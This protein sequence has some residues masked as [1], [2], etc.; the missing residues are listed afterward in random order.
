MTEVYNK[1]VGLTKDVGWQIGVRRTL[2]IP[3][4]VAWQFLISTEGVNLWLGESA[5]VEWT[6][7]A[8]Y[9]LVDGSTGEVRVFKPESH[10]RITWHPADWERAS[11]IQV[12]VMPSGDRTV[13]VFHQEHL[14][15][16]TAREQRRQHFASALDKIEVMLT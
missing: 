11:T 10:V 6:K 3:L 9:E 4:T 16:A 2:D 8:Q 5:G 13:I 14:P 12:R 7:G 15:D 1:P